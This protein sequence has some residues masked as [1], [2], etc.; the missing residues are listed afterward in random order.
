MHRLI[1]AAT[2]PV[3][4]LKPETIEHLAGLSLRLIDGEGET[5]GAASAIAYEAAMTLYDEV[6][7]SRA[8]GRW[9]RR[10]RAAA[11]TMRANLEKPL[12]VVESCRDSRA[13]PRALLAHVCVERRLAACRV[14]PGGAHAPRRAAA[15]R[16]GPASRSRRSP[17]CAG[18]RT[19]TISP[20]CSA[21]SFGT[22]PTEFRTTG[23]YAA[24][25]NVRLGRKRPG[26]VPELR[27]ALPDSNSVR[28]Y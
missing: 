9:R 22:S 24:V 28:R 14:R 19:R 18:S 11:T 7:R 23:M 16:R 4:R 13:Q 5:S 26:R 6:F 27:S 25:E 2:G 20:K 21:A 15:R 17:G 3:F 12:A 8:W 1:L 10:G